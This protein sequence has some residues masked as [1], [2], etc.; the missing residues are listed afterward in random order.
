VDWRDVWRT[1]LARHFLSTPARD[2]DEVV[3]T[4]CGIH[5]QVMSSAELALG[6]RVRA[7]TRSDLHTALWERRT[8]VRTYGLRGT[9]H[10]FGADDLP[11]WLA[12][13][14]ARVPPRGRNQQQQAA[15]PP[16]RVP[17]LIDA[18]G[19]AL[20]GRCLTKAELG[21]ALEERL[22]RW[23]TTRTMPAFGGAMPAW[24]LGLSAAAA[25][26]V[27]AF[28][29]PRGNQ[30]TYER[31]GPLPRVDGQEALREVFRR[32]LHAYGPATHA[33]F[34][35]WF[36]MDPTAA[37]TLRDSMREELEDVD[38]EGWRAW[39][40]RDPPPVAASDEASA[41]LLAQFDCYVVGCHPRA[42][43]MPD[44]VPEAVRKMGT[45]APYAVLLVDGVVRGLW[46]RTRRGRRVEIRVDP[47]RPL[48][49]AQ[50]AQ[51]AGQA[52]RI[53]EILEG[54]VE[55]TYGAV[56]PRWHM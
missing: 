11:L 49:A 15:L 44:D 39:Q 45:A 18:L 30:V 51:V 31:L 4:V 1:R 41:H 5:A 55:L 23:V 40:L 21:R 7:F 50:R 27:L 56:E 14:R 42:Q 19:D 16:D 29:P 33:E 28:G 36:L 9:I 52:E 25:E 32:F 13:L 2:V 12:A 26:G 3:R 34:A 22:G 38:V 37:R 24:Q 48:T 10:I 54:Q 20:E 6:L 46:S 17:R 43:L 53:G 35:R 47:F 8:L